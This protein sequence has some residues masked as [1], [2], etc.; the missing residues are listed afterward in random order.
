MGVD[1]IHPNIYHW[2]LT[3]LSKAWWCIERYVVR[4][5]KHTPCL[6]IIH[7][8][9]VMGSFPVPMVPVN[10]LSQSWWYELFGFYSQLFARAADCLPVP[11]LCLSSRYIDAICDQR[12]RKAQ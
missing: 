6:G 7:N 1:S 10:G 3:G 9:S 12:R 2:C 8:S 5:T 11:G 4:C